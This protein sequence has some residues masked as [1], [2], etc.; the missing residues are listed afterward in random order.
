MESNPNPSFYRLIF[1]EVEEIGWQF[2]LRSSPD[3]SSLVFNLQDEK[4]RSH[5]LEITI[6]RDYPLSSPSISSDVPYMC[7]LEWSKNSKLRD[8]VRQFTEHLQK[9]HEFWSTMDE[10]DKTLCVLHPK[11]P[12]LAM[13]HRQIS[14]GN[15]CSLLMY[16]NA[17]KPKSLPECRWFG[18][19]SSVEIISRKWKRNCR[20]WNTNN[21]F[22]ENL[23][24]LL[25]IELPRKISVSVSKDDEQLDC[26]ICYAHCLPVDNELGDYSGG[27]P[28]Y[29]CENASC[30][31]AFHVVCLRDW[32]RSI[33][34]TRQSFDVLFGNCPYC[35]DAVAVKL[36]IGKRSSVIQQS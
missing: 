31:K 30:S 3:L 9:L 12:S 1:S 27:E 36:N 28:D 6:P 19:D 35:S 5:A 25:E 22:H 7:E 11:Q 33:S 4:G 21:P 8:V 34:T 13:S 18:P 26:G 16:I 24:T 20:N 14:I 29:T 23:E 32:L 17:C 15:E 2:L 10:I